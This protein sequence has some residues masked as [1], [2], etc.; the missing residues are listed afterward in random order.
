MK[1]TI[2]IEVILFFVLAVLIAVIWKQWDS[3]QLS[4]Y[5]YKNYFSQN[6]TLNEIYP[7]LIENIVLTSF[8]TLS[9]IA[10]FVAIVLIAIKDFLIFKP[11]VDKVTARKQARAQTK[12]EKAQAAKQAKIEALEA[13]L[14]ELKKD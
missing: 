8:A 1:R 9:C 3:I 2:I 12:A 7:N 4:F 11:L 10:T 6:H 5:Y 14:E 13:E